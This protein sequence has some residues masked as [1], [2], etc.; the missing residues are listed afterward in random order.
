MINFI[1]I[2]IYINMKGGKFY[3]PI[4]ITLGLA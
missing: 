1:N 4:L 2:Y 3:K